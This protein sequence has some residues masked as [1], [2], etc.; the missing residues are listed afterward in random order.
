V[1][2]DV[3]RWSDQSEADLQDPLNMFLSSFSDIE[4]TDIVTSFI[5]TLAG[6]II[7]TVKVS[8]FLIKNH[9]SMDPSTTP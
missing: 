8:P 2:R 7:P 6:T 5:A 3:K 9:G 1:T 4:F